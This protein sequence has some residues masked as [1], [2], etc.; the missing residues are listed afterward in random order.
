LYFTKKGLFDENNHYFIWFFVFNEEEFVFKCLYFEICVIFEHT[1]IINKKKLYNK[2]YI[3]KKK[4][5]D[6]KIHII[7]N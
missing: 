7:I 1:N 4:G 2:C 6:L 5:K 3:T